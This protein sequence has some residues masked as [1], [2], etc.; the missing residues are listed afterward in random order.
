MSQTV[1]YIGREYERFSQPGVFYGKIPLT[2]LE[3]LWSGDKD[4]LEEADG[5]F[6]PYMENPV[7]LLK[8]LK[9]NSGTYFV[10]EEIEVAFGLTRESAL[11]KFAEMVNGSSS[12]T[13]W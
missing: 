8:E 11:F 2:E 7:D 9:V 3:K 10:D 5:W 1:Y 6:N 12:I 4:A 13:D